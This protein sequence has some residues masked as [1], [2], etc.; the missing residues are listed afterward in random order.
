MGKK[1]NTL[2]FMV[3]ATVLNV[4]LL[5]AFM[6]LGIFLVGKLNQWFPSLSESAMAPPL[7]LL[8]V[9]IISTVLAFF[10]YNKIVK[11]ANKKF[12]LEDKLYPFFSPRRRS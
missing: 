4:V 11:W 9:F 8:A 2:L 6:L 12:H 1:A 5:G 3:I 7:L 10:I